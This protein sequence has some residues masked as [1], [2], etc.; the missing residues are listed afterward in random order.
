[1]RHTATVAC[2]IRV[3]VRLCRRADAGKNPD[4]LASQVLAALKSNDQQ[5]LETL[6]ITPAEFKK[7]IWPTIAVNVSGGGQ[8]TADKFYVMYRKSSEVGLTQHLAQFGG[9]LTNWSGSTPDRQSNI[10][11]TACCRT[12]KSSCV[13]RAQKNFKARQRIAGA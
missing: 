6:A 5:A 2:A 10:T 9:S 8:M 13:V 11:T 4:T 12:R 7:Y 1:M 3:S